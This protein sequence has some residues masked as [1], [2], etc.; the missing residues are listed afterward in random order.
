[1]VESGTMSRGVHASTVGPPNSN[2]KGKKS[3][4]EVKRD[5]LKL[6]T[7]GFLK[8]ITVNVLDNIGR[9]SVGSV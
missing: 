4:G 2:P 7:E 8:R 6:L 1:M 3:Q 9:D 5:T